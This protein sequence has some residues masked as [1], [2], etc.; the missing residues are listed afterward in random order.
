MKNRLFTVFT[1]V[2][3]FLAFSSNASAGLNGLC[4]AVA[5]TGTG[6]VSILDINMEGVPNNIGYHVP[7]EDTLIVN[8][9]DNGNPIVYVGFEYAIYYSGIGWGAWQY[10]GSSTHDASVVDVMDNT[11]KWHLPHTLAG[12]SIKFRMGDYYDSTNTKTYSCYVGSSSKKESFLT[13]P[14]I[15]VSCF[16]NPVV[17]ELR[18]LSNNTQNTI[19]SIQIHDM[20]GN[21]VRSQYAD[22]TFIE[23]INVADLPKGTYVAII[24]EE[25][26]VKVVKN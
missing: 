21:A 14:E 25:Q 26:F 13:S 12:K 24:N 19:N 22:G 10:I 8:W 1:L 9:A 2:L 7:S 18:I 15:G 23:V 5:E 20:N 17:N 16:P 4:L 11:Y 6:N 3:S